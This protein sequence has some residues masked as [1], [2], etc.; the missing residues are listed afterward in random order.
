M[1]S[2]PETTNQLQPVL[3]DLNDHTNI[4]RSHNNK[5]NFEYITG[6][7]TMLGTYWQSR[8]LVCR[9][10]TGGRAAANSRITG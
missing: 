5:T 6:I 3:S 4:T 2:A 1:Q 7:P 9:V 8:R 10:I